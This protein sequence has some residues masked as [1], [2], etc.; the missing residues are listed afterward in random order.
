MWPIVAS[1]LLAAPPLPQAR[2]V[3]VV[4]GADHA[5]L[6]TEAMTALERVGLHPALLDLSAFFE[7]QPTS[8]SAHLDCL[9]R[10]PALNG[11]A[12]VLVLRVSRLSGTLRAIDLRRVSC[13]DSSRRARLSVVLAEAELDAWVRRSAPRIALAPQVTASAVPGAQTAASRAPRSRP[14][15]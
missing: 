5:R 7:L 6:S 10:A 13:K 12:D 4:D 2:P 11:A 1:L 15:R 14:A 3:V 8:C 9:C